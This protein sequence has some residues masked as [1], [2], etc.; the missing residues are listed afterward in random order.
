MPSADADLGSITHCVRRSEQAALEAAEVAAA[1]KGGGLRGGRHAPERA[2]PSD[3]SALP[4]A[5]VAAVT[6]DV[7]NNGSS[8]PGGIFGEAFHRPQPVGLRGEPMVLVPGG[9]PG[10]RGRNGPSIAGGIFPVQEERQQPAARAGFDPSQRSIWGRWGSPSQ[11][12]NTTDYGHAVFPRQ[13]LDVLNA[14]RVHGF[15]LAKY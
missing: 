3:V 13:G 1:S 10:E 8:V 15:E 4:M 9:R 6:G 12:V 5:G 14:K 7:L 11:R 2:A